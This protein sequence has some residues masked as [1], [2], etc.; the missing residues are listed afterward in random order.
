[1]RPSNDDSTLNIR[2]NTI[3]RTIYSRRSEHIHTNK[4]LIKLFKSETAD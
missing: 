3:D 4:S 2:T 1:M